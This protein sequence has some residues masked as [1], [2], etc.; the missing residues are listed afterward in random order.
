M[1]K[2]HN[3]FLRVFCILFILI[4]QTLEA[5]PSPELSD[6]IESLR[7]TYGIQPKNYV[8]YPD[9]PID[10]VIPCVA[11]DQE[12][13]K[14]SIASIRAYCEGVRR[15]IV[16][17]SEPIDVEAEWFDE[18]NF[19][20]NKLDIALEI[21]PSNDQAV[22]FIQTKHSRIGWIYQQLLKL[23]APFV[24]PD[25]S[26][27]VLILDADTILLRPTRFMDESGAAFFNVGKENHKPYFEHMARLLPYMQRVDPKYSGITHHMLFQ[28]S[29]LKDFI[30]QVK[31]AHGIPMW[32]AIL[33]CIDLRYV[34][35]SSFSEY[36][37]YFNFC[38]LNTDQYNIRPLK[39][40]N[41]NSLD[42]IEQYQKD[43]YFF[44]SYHKYF[45]MTW[46][47]SLY[48]RVPLE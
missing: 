30:S 41:V 19:P 27:N 32:K 24:I 29:I 35:R 33:R 25:I 38:L 1:K 44:V 12:T 42:L 40:A 16:V 2:K 4:K 6:R 23:Y 11:K 36:E 21:F 5:V 31:K 7:S 13:V 18:S 20:F 9:D 45:R 46:P 47:T 37:M 15:I 48:S 10:V 17:S 28:K 14:Y 8:L 3:S 26:S 22:Q 43:D 34:S 39:Y